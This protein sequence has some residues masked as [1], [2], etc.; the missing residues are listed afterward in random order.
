MKILHSS[1]FTAILCAALV[2]PV[3]AQQKAIGV[4]TA[5][6]PGPLSTVGYPGPAVGI[7]A[8]FQDSAALAFPVVRQGVS[9]TRLADRPQKVLF[10]KSPAANAKEAIGNLLL[11]D[12]G[13]T[14]IT[15]ALAPQMRMWNPYLND[16]SRKGVELGK[17]ILVG[18]GSDTKGFEYDTLPGATAEVT[19]KEGNAE[20]LMPMN[21]YLPSADFDAAGVQP[22]LVRLEPRDRDNARLI[23]SR[24]VVLK[25][26]TTGRF[27][28]KPTLERQEIGVEQHLIAVSV[29]RIPGNVFKVI[30]EAPLVVGEYGLVFRRA[31]DTGDYVQNVPLKPTPQSP[32]AMPGA[33]GGSPPLKAEPAPSRSP[34]GMMRRGGN[35]GVPAQSPAVSQSN[36]AAFIAWDF[37]V[38][39][40]T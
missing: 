18:H 12:V 5:D 34:F 14:L 37:R 28:L 40:Y 33:M 27:D 20:F 38:L 15:M 7:V 17:G 9:Q 23:T 35:P 36:T 25:Q 13:L 32:S 4:P 30:P 6:L 8:S 2:T 3:P 1:L 16:G 26:N 22:V 31:A 19:L 21:N 39:K 24:Q 11:S 29:E 10:V